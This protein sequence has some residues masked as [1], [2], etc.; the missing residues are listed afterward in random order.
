M[1]LLLRVNLRLLVEFNGPAVLAQSTQPRH[2][3]EGHEMSHLRTPKNAW[4]PCVVVLKPL[5][6]QGHSQKPAAKVFPEFPEFEAIRK[7]LPKAGVTGVPLS[8]QVA[9]G[10]RG[11]CHFLD[12]PKGNWNNDR[13]HSADIDD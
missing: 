11:H 12:L 13:S 1:P 2:S 8:L 6:K 7:P 4:F 9:G 10:F 3:I 5:S